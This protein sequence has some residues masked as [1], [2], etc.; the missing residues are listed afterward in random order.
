MDRPAILLLA[1]LL[2]TTAWPDTADAASKRARAASKRAKPSG[3]KKPPSKKK[4]PRD[5]ASAPPIE[6]GT[7]A[8]EATA[9]PKIPGQEGPRPWA[10]GVS[11]ENQETAL[12][13]FNKGNQ[14]LLKQT[15]VEAAATFRKALEHWKHPAIQYNLSECLIHLDRPIEAYEHVVDSLRFG[16]AAL[17]DDLF[18]RAQTRKKLL[19]GQLAMIQLESGH[20]GVKVMLDGEL[21]FIAPGQTTQRVRP[22]RHDLLAAKD[23][24]LPYNQTVVA[25]PNEP[26]AVNI[27][28]RPIPTV[29]YERR[30]AAWMPWTV[31][32]L[33]LASS[34]AGIVLQ[35]QARSDMDA[36]DAGVAE[37]CP[38]GCPEI[39]ISSAILDKRD[40]AERA[41]TIGVS[42]LAVGG[43]VLATG[44]VMLIVNQP[45]KV[46]EGSPVQV[47]PTA[48]PGGAGVA[49]SM[50]F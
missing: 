22:G 7:P 46:V 34:A 11:A 42:M 48:T 40:A 16:A 20:H 39:E 45:K 8:P 31:A 19:E 41:S 35:A 33:G 30:F 9:S 1:G 25:L 14:E 15:Y 27:H 21:V 29:R 50:T 24:F 44:V 5:E 37:Q 26:V 43:A 6:Q 18:T 38:S 17:G 12:A 28:L 2:S 10:E 23:G 32:G 49:M 3:K 47:T 36:Y 4:A 13:L